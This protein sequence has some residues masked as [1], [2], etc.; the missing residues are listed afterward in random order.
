MFDLLFIASAVV[1]CANILK[2]SLE[3]VIPMENWAN[4]ELINEDISKNIPVEQRI[5]N[6][7]DG[8][9]KLTNVY[10]EPH[11][12]NGKINIENTLLY[13]KDVE[14]YGYIQASKW[15]RQGKYNL[16][17]EEQKKELKRLEEYYRKLYK[18]K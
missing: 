16:S 2:E 3:P 4:K 18:M 15:V 11:K 12:I 14:K 5:K 8:K 17:P 10:E 1:T 13:K 6:A 9:Y 7:R